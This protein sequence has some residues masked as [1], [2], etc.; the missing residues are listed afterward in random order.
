MH[1]AIRLIVVIASVGWFE[2]GCAS[3]FE[4][5]TVAGAVKAS[6]AFGFDLYRQ[7]RIGREN[8]VCSPAGAAIAL[9][10]TAAGA[11]GETQAE[12]LRVLHI[13]PVNLD[14]T[15]S[16]YAAVL[17]ALKD[18]DGKDDLSLTVANRIWVQ[19]KL[20]LRPDYLALLRERFRAPLG[21]LDFARAPAEALSAINRWSSD[22]T[23]GRIPEILNRLSQATRMVLANAVYMKA[24]WARPFE[25]GDT[26]DEGFTTPAGRIKTKT[27]RQMRRFKYA[28]VRGAKLLELPYQGAMSMVIVLPDAP[29]GLRQIEDRV[30]TSYSGWIQE[31]E[32]KLVDLELPRFT[33][34]TTL[35]LV[36]LLKALGMKQA[37]HGGKANFS[38]MFSGMNDHG[39]AKPPVRGP[40]DGMGML[41]I[42][43]AI[44]KAWIETNELGTEAAAV[45]VV[46]MGEDLR[47][48]PG[49]KPKPVVFHADHPFLYLIRDT[50]NGV[51][52]FAGRVVNPEEAEPEAA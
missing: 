39:L 42:K 47:A 9:T 22:E 7:V 12:M 13:D 25:R 44:Q 15:Y 17:A 3:S 36:A 26:R 2:A 41:H 45:T 51:I 4:A 30:P 28:E 43:E 5:S 20:K 31:L 11:R 37:F 34:E 24:K 10:M 32:Y 18:Y 46:V 50:K 14:Q 1:A 8:F 21:E 49:P 40:A 6:N 48:T 29:D 38:G 33:T 23:H 35:P 19:E 16:S 52:L 27:M